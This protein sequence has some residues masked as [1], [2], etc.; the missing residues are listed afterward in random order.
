MP[1]IGTVAPEKPL[2]STGA[3]RE[4]ASHNPSVV[5]SSPTRPTQVRALV[6][7]GSGVGRDQSRCECATV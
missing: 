6:A 7:S 2:V 4:R 5:G 1:V 3:H